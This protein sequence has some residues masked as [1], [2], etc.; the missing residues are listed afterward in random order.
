MY[1]ICRKILGPAIRER[2]EGNLFTIKARFSDKSFQ[3][4]V[5]DITFI[6]MFSFPE[7]FSSALLI[8]LDKK[9]PNGVKKS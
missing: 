7:C 8:K 2:H 1:M 3:Y 4:P 5:K 6:S 9:S